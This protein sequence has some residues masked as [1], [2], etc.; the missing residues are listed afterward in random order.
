MLCPTR[1]GAGGEYG[2]GGTEPGTHSLPPTCHERVLTV[3]EVSY[4][5]RGPRATLADP[6]Q[7]EQHGAFH[8]T[9]L[10][11]FLAEFNAVNS[12]PLAK[13]QVLLG[14]EIKETI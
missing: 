5:C 9:F 6:R 8:L 10:L 2:R 13:D 4:F 11:G 1:D 7:D 14:T 3:T 12:P